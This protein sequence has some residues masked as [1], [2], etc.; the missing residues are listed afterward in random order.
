MLGCRG[1]SPL[2]VIYWL[3]WVIIDFF[4]VHWSQLS[5]QTASNFSSHWATPHMH[6]WAF[7]YHFLWSP[8]LWYCRMEEFRWI[9][10][11]LSFYFFTNPW[12]M[13][14]LYLS[15]LCYSFRPIL[16]II[17]NIFSGFFLNLPIDV[18]DTFGI[19]L[20]SVNSLLN[21]TF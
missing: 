18:N 16:F 2:A 13:L 21:L 14:L 17:F 19:C 4:K 8:S 3:S 1:K 9:F 12:F 5:L 6:T 15:N 11:F 7:S 10:L 20:N